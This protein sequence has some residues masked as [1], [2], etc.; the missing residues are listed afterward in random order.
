MKP[1]YEG[2]G[3]TVF[4]CSMEDV[5]PDLGVVDMILA[6]P[7]YFEVR[8][9]F[10]FKW[11]SFDEYLVDVE[12]YEKLQ[13]RITLLEGIARG[14]SAIDDGRTLSNAQARKKM[15]RWLK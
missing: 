2:R 15:A 12:S 10:D 11:R 13:A 4:N 14:E 3:C 7:P 1:Y 8:G 9:E 6:D 5:V